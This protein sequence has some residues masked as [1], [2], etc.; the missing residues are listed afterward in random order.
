MISLTTKKSARFGIPTTL[1]LLLVFSSWGP[2]AAA[3]D[4]VEGTGK[5]TLLHFEITQGL[6]LVRIEGRKVDADV[7]GIHDSQGSQEQLMR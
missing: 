5:P 6:G 7:L 2:I 1:I 3:D 4:G